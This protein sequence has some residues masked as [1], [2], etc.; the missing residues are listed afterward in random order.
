[1][2]MTGLALPQ[3]W[4][5]RMGRFSW[6][7]TGCFVFTVL[8][9]IWLLYQAANHDLGVRPVTEATHQTGDWAIR[10]LLATLAV[11]PLRRAAQWPRLLIV[12]RMLGLACLS[13]VSIHFCLYIVDQKY[14]LVKVASEIVLRFYLLIGFAAFF[15]L[16]VLGWTSTDGAVKRM[17]AEASPPAEASNASAPT[18]T[19][20][21]GRRLWPFWGWPPCRHWRAAP[22]RRSGTGSPPASTAGACWL[23]TWIGTWR[24]GPRIGCFWAGWR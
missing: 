14:D 16:C 21:L 4:F 24:Q 15:G 1:M 23:R 7:K 8:P 5:D 6:L 2:S 3:P 17:G 19:A 11:T 12:R 18:V 20:N 10:F 13:Y 9:A 22:A